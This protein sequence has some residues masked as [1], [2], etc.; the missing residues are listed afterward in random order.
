MLELFIQDYYFKKYEYYTY[1][2]LI[3]KYD[4][5]I[6]ELGKILNSTKANVVQLKIKN[7]SQFYNEAS[8]AKAEL[9]LWQIY[10]MNEVAIIVK[11]DV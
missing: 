6:E 2:D 8:I 9:G 4:N 10:F 5:N 1:N 3:F 7:Y 11:K